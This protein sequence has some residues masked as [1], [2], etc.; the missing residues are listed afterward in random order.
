M[1]FSLYCLLDSF[2][3]SYSYITK[4]KPSYEYLESKYIK[5]KALSL[6]LYFTS[7]I[8]IQ[9]TAK[10]NYGNNILFCKFD[11]QNNKQHTILFVSALLPQ[12]FSAFF[13]PY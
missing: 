9:W 6:P 4:I 7:K 2:H 13:I 5:G 8:N 11:A 12:S 1:Y 10:L 3:E